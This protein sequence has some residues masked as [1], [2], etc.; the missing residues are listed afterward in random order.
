MNEQTKQ[1]IEY[2]FEKLGIAVDWTQENV[3]PRVEQALHKFVIYNIVKSSLDVAIG[4][5]LVAIAIIICVMAAKKYFAA[6]DSFFWD[7][8]H[9]DKEVTGAG[10]V[11]LLFAMIFFLVGG[12]VAAHYL[13]SLIEWAVAP[14]VRI[15]KEILEI[16]KEVQ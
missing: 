8:F 15:I 2:V 14:E 6:G 5:A 16:S 13:S 7:D 4:V 11:L 3:A 9:G 1:T 12:F 10:C